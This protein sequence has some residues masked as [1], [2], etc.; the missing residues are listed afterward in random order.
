MVGV[1]DNGPVACSAVLADEAIG[2][3]VIDDSSG[4]CNN[5]DSETFSQVVLGIPVNELDLT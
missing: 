4:Q 3:R 2:I 1:E 5:D